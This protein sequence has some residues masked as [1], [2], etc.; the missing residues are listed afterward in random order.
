M[1]IANSPVSIAAVL[2]QKFIFVTYNSKNHNMTF[3]WDGLC[4][5]QQ[6]FITVEGRKAY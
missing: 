6:N 2:Y 1:E 3:L 4:L 5:L